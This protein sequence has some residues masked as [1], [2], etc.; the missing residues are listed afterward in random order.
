MESEEHRVRKAV[1]AQLKEQ[2]KDKP[3]YQ[4]TMINADQIKKGTNVLAVYSNVGYVKEQP[5]GQIDVF[6]EGLKKK[7]LE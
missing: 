1:A 2:M 6:L 4:R 5:L 7:D 3:H